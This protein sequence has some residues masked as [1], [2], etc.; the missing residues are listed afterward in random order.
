MATP[1]NY[2]LCVPYFVMKTGAIEIS[3]KFDLSGF[4]QIDW[5][6]RND[7]E[8]ITR[9]LI[10]GDNRSAVIVTEK[11]DTLLFGISELNVE[12][13]EEQG[14]EECDGK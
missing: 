14:K 7:G 3:F 6:G 2:S 8:K 11:G 5:L 9:I 1:K 4:P 12:Y 13:N 10:S